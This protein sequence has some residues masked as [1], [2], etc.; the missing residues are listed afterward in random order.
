[1]PLKLNS[2]KAKAELYT[3]SEMIALI[4]VAF[5]R[6]GQSPEGIHTFLSSFK[7]FESI[8][9]TWTDVDMDKLSFVL[10]D[11]ILC[12]LETI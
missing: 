1:M 4:D 3:W 5:E 2:S 10:Q 9:E 11:G 12:R 7:F 6:D 8:P